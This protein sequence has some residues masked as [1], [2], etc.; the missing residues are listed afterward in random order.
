MTVHS[1]VENT[2]HNCAGVTNAHNINGKTLPELNL[3]GF[4]VGG[5]TSGDNVRRKE[6]VW[7]KSE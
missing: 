3:G 5:A 6:V 2:T 4:A 1:K 7:W